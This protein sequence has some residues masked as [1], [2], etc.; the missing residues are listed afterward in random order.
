MSWEELIDRGRE[1]PAE[2]PSRPTTDDLCTIMYAGGRGSEDCMMV[3]ISAEHA[4]SSQQFVLC[5][6]TPQGQQVGD[7]SGRDNVRLPHLPLSRN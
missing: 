2:P 1:S 6:G 3:I 5:A 4:P 7:N